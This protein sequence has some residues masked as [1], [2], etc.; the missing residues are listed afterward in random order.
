[1]ENSEEQV[2]KKIV[3]LFHEL[4][5][6]KGPLKKVSKEF[7][8]DFMISGKKYKCVTEKTLSYNLPGEKTFGAPLEHIPE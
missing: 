8:F 3:S 2:V 1:M 5:E 7:I 4:T 6:E